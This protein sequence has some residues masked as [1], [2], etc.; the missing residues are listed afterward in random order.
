MFILVLQGL[1]EGLLRVAVRFAVRVWRVG[2]G[3]GDRVVQGA[4]KGSLGLFY[5]KIQKHGTSLS[6]FPEGKV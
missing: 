2:L 1:L 5:S 6:S 4:F 3:F